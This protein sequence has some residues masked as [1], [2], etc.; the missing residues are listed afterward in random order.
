M[1]FE[2]IQRVSQK[3]EQERSKLKYSYFYKSRRS[4]FKKAIKKFKNK[5]EAEKRKSLKRAIT[6][7]GVEYSSQKE[8]AQ[9]H[10][11]KKG[12]S[13]LRFLKR[14][15][16]NHSFI[17]HENNSKGCSAIKINET[18]FNTRMQAASEMG[19]SHTQS[20]MHHLKSNPDKYKVIFPYNIEDSQ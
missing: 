1:Y 4:S 7:D 8:A 3:E 10:G 18:V 6:V 13:F 9:A 20:L 5:Y 14:G 16:H 15:N 2:Q 17:L 11:W 19:Y 12:Y